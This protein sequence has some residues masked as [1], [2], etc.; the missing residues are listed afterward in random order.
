MCAFAYIYA[1]LLCVSKIDILKW[2][3]KQESF[4]SGIRSLPT[5]I[6]IVYDFKDGRLYYDHK[7]YYKHY[8][9]EWEWS[10]F[11]LKPKGMTFLAISF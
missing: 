4:I 7:T 11:C 5:V 10:F 6:N 1:V 3:A 9:G 8:R 2:C